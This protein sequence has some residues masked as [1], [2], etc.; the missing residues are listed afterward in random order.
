MGPFLGAR[1]G[2][3]KLGFFVALFRL[4]VG[5]GYRPLTPPP[6]GVILKLAE[7]AGPAP[8]AALTALEKVLPVLV[9]EP[10]HPT[11]RNFTLLT[12]ATAQLA[13]QG[14]K[15]KSYVCERGVVPTVSFP[16]TGVP[17]MCAGLFLLSLL[18]IDSLGPVNHHG[19]NIK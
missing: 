7:G 10:P 8:F 4:G 14:I 19:W 11:T 16:G 12:L 13:Q 17:S 1:G 2:A 3:S 5:D 18:L 15:N 9:V 6:L